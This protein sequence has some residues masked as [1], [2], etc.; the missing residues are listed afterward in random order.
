MAN[1]KRKKETMLDRIER[2]DAASP[3]R[4]AAR[5]GMKTR[6]G[7]SYG[8]E[9]TTSCVACLLVLGFVTVWCCLPANAHQTSRGGGQG[10][11]G[12]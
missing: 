1:G 9:V 3:V 7:N 12:R 8:R 6:T 2:S 11:R 10:E 5:V 4:K